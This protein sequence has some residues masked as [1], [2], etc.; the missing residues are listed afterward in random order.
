MARRRFVA[1]ARGDVDPARF[2]APIF[3]D[4]AAH[5]AWLRDR[6]WPSIDAL[7]SA[8]G[9]PP[10]PYSGQ[11]LCFVAQTPALLADGLHYERRI[12]DTGA[13]A[14]RAGNW[15]DLFN[16]LMWFERLPLKAAANLR[17]AR[18]VARAG[19]ER[20]RA[21]CALTH[22]DEGGALVVLRDAALLAHW[23]AHDWESLFGRHADAWRDGRADVVVFG[24][25]LLEHALAPDPVHTAKCLV[26]HDEHATVDD[27]IARAA[28]AIVVGACLTDPQ[29]LR[30][31]P[32]SGLPGWHRHGVDAA[33]LRDAPCF[34]PL[35]A[36]RVYPPPLTRRDRIPDSSA[37]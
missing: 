28:A 13:I 37:A 2:D 19:N 9:A 31:L 7:N 27:A 23:D 12:H 29:E 17:Q 1:P 18:D 32:L 24:H 35:R 33:F 8:F 5:A 25:A 14:T 30:P 26:V 10:H 16:A 15:H 34:R 22:F 20:T 11:P 36:G 3:G 21:Q 4:F 6:D